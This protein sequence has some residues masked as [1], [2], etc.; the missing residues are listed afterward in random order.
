VR[1]FPIPLKQ[2]YVARYSWRIPHCLGPVQPCLQIA[3]IATS[4]WKD[5][6][7]MAQSNLEATTAAKEAAP[8]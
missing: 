5:Q 8:G 2:I 1:A 3:P 7:D 4:Q 6:R